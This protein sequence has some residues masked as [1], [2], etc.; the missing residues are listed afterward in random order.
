MVV[1]KTIC[2][3]CNEVTLTQ[4]EIGLCKKL[5]GEKIENYFCISCLADY[6]DTTIE[7]LNAKIGDFKEQG[8]VLF[9]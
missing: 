4:N 2:T 8:C 1:K 5:L 3:I 9:S 6:L 7:D